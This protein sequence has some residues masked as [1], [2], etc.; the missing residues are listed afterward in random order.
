MPE[1][2]PGF[3]P[4]RY[5]FCRGKGPF[6]NEM[7]DRLQPV[8]DF[9]LAGWPVSLLAPAAAGGAGDPMAAAAIAIASLSM[10]ASHA[11]GS[12]DPC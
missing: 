9:D 1:P 10:S 7:R 2:D 11:D 8:A 12:P 6:C 3:H 4:Y 5:H